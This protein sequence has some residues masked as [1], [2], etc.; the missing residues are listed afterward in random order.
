MCT[1]HNQNIS[2][3]HCWFTQPVQ[4]DP[5]AVIQAYLLSREMFLLPPSTQSSSIPLHSAAIPLLAT[6]GYVDNGVFYEIFSFSTI[7]LKER[8]YA[9]ISFI[10][11]GKILRH[12]RR[13][14]HNEDILCKIFWRISALMFEQHYSIIKGRLY[15]N[16]MSGVKASLYVAI[17]NLQIS[18]IFPRII[19]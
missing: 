15:A 11:K 18:L 10:P 9:G 3:L 17:S 4:S 19:F 5:S 1:P 12:A 2:P 6:T 16:H 7:D 8:F 13:F 14:V